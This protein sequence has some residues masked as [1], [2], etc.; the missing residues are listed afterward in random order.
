MYKKILVA[1]DSS[2]PSTCAISAAVEVA[3]Q[4]NAEIML[5]HVVDVTAAYTPEVGI[6]GSKLAE[7]REQGDELLT[8]TVVRLSHVHNVGR[9]MLEG[10]PAD[11]I[12]AAAHDWPADLIVIGSDSHGRLAHFL[13][14]STADSVIRRALCPVMSVR[15]DTANP[16]HKPGDKSVLATTETITIR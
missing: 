8:E 7:L 16:A 14:G 5:V 15:A 2:Q 9:L 1:I 4:L 10:D 11:S 6:S 13:L 3:Q 12:L